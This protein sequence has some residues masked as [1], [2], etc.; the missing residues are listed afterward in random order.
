MAPVAT[1]PMT[2]LSL[3]FMLSMLRDDP[4]MDGSVVKKHHWTYAGIEGPEHWSQSYQHCGGKR[5]SPIDIVSYACLYDSTL[6]D[7]RLSNFD[8]LSTQVGMGTNLNFTN[9]GHAA[10]VRVTGNMF[11][12]GGGLRGLYRTAE[13][14]FHWGSR[15]DMGSEHAIEGV[16]YPLEMHVVNY[17]ARY[18]TLLEAVDQDDGL[19]VLG[20]LFE[21]SDQDNPAF[22]PLAESLQYI[23]KAGE[24]QMVGGVRLRSLLPRDTSR[25]YQYSGSLTTPKCLETVTWTIFEEP[26]KISARQ[27]ARLRD[28][29]HENGHY[30]DVTNDPKSGSV[31]GAHNAHNYL[32]DNWRPLQ[33]LHSRIIKQSFAF[34]SPRTGHKTVTKDAGFAFPFEPALP[35][36]VAVPAP[37]PPPVSSSPLPMPSS[38]LLVASSPKPGASPIVQ[39]TTT[40]DAGPNPSPYTYRNTNPEGVADP[41]LKFLTSGNKHGAPPTVPSFKSMTE[42]NYTKGQNTV[43]SGAARIMPGNGQQHKVQSTGSKD[44]LPAVDR[45]LTKRPPLPVEDHT[46][47]SSTSVV[48]VPGASAGRQQ[49]LG[50]SG[51]TQ[52]PTSVDITS[53]AQ[54]SS[55]V[56]HPALHPLEPQPPSSTDV[57]TTL[58]PKHSVQSTG[59]KDQLQAVD[60]K[61]M[62][63]P[64]LPVEDHTQNSSTTVLDVPGASSG[65]QQGLGSGSNTQLPTS[66]GITSNAQPSSSVGHAALHPLEP[67][68]PSSTDV[69]TTLVPSEQHPST[70]GAS[71]PSAEESTTRNPS[72]PFAGVSSPNQDNGQQIA[73]QER[74]HETV[75]K[76]AGL[77]FTSEPALPTPVAVPAPTPPPVSSSPL[78]MSS[79]SLLVASSPKPEASPMVQLTTTTDAGPNHSPYTYKNTNPEGV[80]DPSL[81]FLTSGNK[82]GAPP[83][84]PS[85]KSMTEFNNTKG[86]NTVLSGAARIM[87]GNGQQHRVQSTGSKDQLQ[88]VDSK[89]MERPPL[90][91]EDHTQNSSTTTVLDVPG[92]GSGSNTQLPT[93]VDITSN[94]QPSSSV[95]H[96]ALHPLEPQPPSSTDVSTTL[97]PSEQ[98]PS[99]AG[100]SSPS[101]EESTT[102][103]PSQPFA[104]VSSPNQDNGQQIANQER[105]NATSTS[106]G[107][108]V[109]TQ[110]STPVVERVSSPQ[111]FAGVSS[112]NQDNGQQIANQERGNATSTSTGQSVD[113]QASTPV[114]ERVSSPQSASAAHRMNHETSEPAV[115]NTSETTNQTTTQERGNATSTHTGQSVDTQASTPVVATVDIQKLASLLRQRLVEK[116]RL[117]LKTTSSSSSSTPLTGRGSTLAPAFDVNNQHRAWQQQQRQKQLHAREQQIR[118]QRINQ[119]LQKQWRLMQQ[120]QG[121]SGARTQQST[122]TVY[123]I[124]PAGVR[125]GSISAS[126]RASSNPL[127]QALGS[128]RSTF[129]RDATTNHITSGSARVRSLARTIHPRV[130]SV[131]IRPQLVPA[132]RLQGERT[133][134][135]SVGAS[136]ATPYVFLHTNNRNIRIRTVAI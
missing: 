83:T 44:Q 116:Q 78:P 23:H 51:N 45:K 39:L 119:I 126:P 27:L 111:P 17:A 12:E 102:R 117:A 6:P 49:G 134:L 131:V 62:E 77:A 69:S 18:D 2:K 25:F 112:P 56:G 86:Q 11:V 133:V 35:T 67:Q 127:T 60:S 75:T 106:T 105:G 118:Q 66:V 135:P 124:T 3:Y 96:P 88:A 22:E 89:L 20:V 71:S 82:Q 33:A 13:F 28:L 7:F 76:D 34:A 84:V 90:P 8:A 129:Y 85:F 136:R 87:P 110:A 114:V 104:G 16:K 14:H 53:N 36:P 59:S 32:V 48:D 4:T 130:H 103:N 107:Q 80:A 29:L 108:S 115:H 61:L 74:G 10:S 57:S 121:L 100:A 42:F 97:V 21:I 94:A 5:Q 72:Q 65:R 15:D 120:Q 58:V 81:E 19:A 92:L 95:G 128:L 122:R 98:H 99:T 63:R 43:L 68:P 123:S 40:T 9:N 41:S 31:G 93:S 109:D 24:F 101:A 47:N 113:T 91:V 64:P 50:S 37:T 30:S 1:V 38:S 132:Y 55:S 70:A 73:N 79:S 52:L 125:R 46:Q 54:P 26:Q